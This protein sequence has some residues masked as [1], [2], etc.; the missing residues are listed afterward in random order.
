MN[1]ARRFNGFNL[2]NIFGSWRNNTNCKLI[3]NLF[4][5]DNLEKRKSNMQTYFFL[6]NILPKQQLTKPTRNPNNNV[7]RAKMT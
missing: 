1:N 4:P 3:V 5:G 2:S 6:S 7:T